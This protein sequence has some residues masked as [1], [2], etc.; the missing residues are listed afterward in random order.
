MYGAAYFNPRIE[1]AWPLTSALGVRVERGGTIPRREVEAA[2]KD[3]DIPV[4]LPPV[5]DVV[6]PRELNK[7]LEGIGMTA[8]ELLR[9]GIKFFADIAPKRKVLLPPSGYLSWLDYAIATMDTR[10]LDNDI[11]WGNAPQWPDNTTREEMQAAA[12][13]E[14]QALRSNLGVERA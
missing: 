12:K 13:A 11:S 7:L 9:R 8:D 14:L 5:G 1:P 4:T 6:D 3:L 2:L 10:S